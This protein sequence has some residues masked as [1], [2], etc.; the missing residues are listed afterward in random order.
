MERRTVSGY[1]WVD[2][3]HQAVRRID[4]DGL[5]RVSIQVGDGVDEG[6]PDVVAFRE[7]V[8]EGNVPQE[9]PTEAATTAANEAAAAL[10]AQRLASV[11][12]V[13]T[14]KVAVDELIVAVLQ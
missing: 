1:Q 5:M 13:P 8:A 2:S 12:E 10:E 4:D 11:D 9:D 6:H 14:L 7:W 3:S